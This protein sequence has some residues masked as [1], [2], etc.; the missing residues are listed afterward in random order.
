MWKENLLVDITSHLRLF[1]LSTSSILLAQLVKVK[2][3]CI[4]LDFLTLFKGHV[5][6]DCDIL[7]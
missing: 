2:V 7:E 4:L 1:F 5:L 6:T 3:N